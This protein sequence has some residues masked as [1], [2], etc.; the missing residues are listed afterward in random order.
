MPLEAN[1]KRERGAALAAVLLAMSL[2]LPLG[3]LAVLQA[4]IGLLT[5]QSLRGDAEALHAA[6]A[7]IACALVRLEAS[8]DFDLALR[9]PDAIAGSADDG[10]P[11]F[12]LDCV[13]ALPSSSF[14]IRL[15][16]G[17]T[18]EAIV[19][20]ST[21]RGLR[22]AMRTVEQH[23]RRGAAAALEPVGWRER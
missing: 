15:E 8:G 14:E 7:G 5:Q 1:R 21:G 12:A 23:V 10:V 16:P 3:A 4:R 13:P 6:E 17:R 9:G 2:L 22:G 18:A 20:V 19:I 11:P